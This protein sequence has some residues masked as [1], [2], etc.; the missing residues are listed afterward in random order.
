MIQEL[1]LCAHDFQQKVDDFDLVLVFKS[2]LGM[3]YHTFLILC[4]IKR[5]K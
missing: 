2:N 4:L 5:D 3:L 1:R